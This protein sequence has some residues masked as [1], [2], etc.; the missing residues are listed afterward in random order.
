MKVLIVEDTD[1]KLE[2]LISFFTANYNADITQA[3]SFKNGSSEIKNGE[4]DIIILDMSMPTY[5]ISEGDRGGGL[6][7]FAG[8]DLLSKISRKGNTPV[9][10]I[11]R[12]DVLG[13]EDNKISLA[14]YDKRLTKEFSNNY[15]GY[16]FYDEAST[17]IWMN[18][19][20][21]LIGKSGVK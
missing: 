10:V 1:V 2:Q 17:S 13:P 12:F 18:R 21:N 16:V 7:H 3:K 14:E 6:R 9:I 20:K 15:R 4:F 11:T 8:R 19:L 5:D